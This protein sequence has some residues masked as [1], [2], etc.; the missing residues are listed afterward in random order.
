[1]GRDNRFSFP[2]FYHRRMEYNKHFVLCFS[3]ESNISD[4]LEL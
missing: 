4:R 2:F 1:M 3:P